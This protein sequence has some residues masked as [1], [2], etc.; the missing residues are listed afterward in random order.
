[1]NIRVLTI[2]LLTS[3]SC[4]NISKNEGEKANVIT[5]S[6]LSKTLTS[7][8]RTKTLKLI[9][10]LENPINLQEFKKKKRESLSTVT[11]GSEYYWNP[12]IKDSIFYSYSFLPNDPF[13]SNIDQLKIIVFKYGR[14]KH[15]WDDN[16]EILIE[17]KIETQDDHLMDANLVGLSIEQIEK[18]FGTDYLQLEN[19]MVYSNRN[20]VLILEIDNSRVAFMNY[21]KLNTEK[22]DLDLIEQLID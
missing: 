15:T 1:M 16:S 20:K 13:Q 14:N 21:I 9:S 4:K 6:T 22:I 7:E 17:L 2:L 3:L 11:N 10:F 18:E 8:N 5:D 19:R 12:K